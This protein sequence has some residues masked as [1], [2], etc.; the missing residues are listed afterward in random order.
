[1]SLAEQNAAAIEKVR[2]SLNEAAA[3]TRALHDAKHPRA[4]VLLYVI[5]LAIAE[6]DEMGAAARRTAH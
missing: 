4:P 2:Q 5:E 6:A 3:I 1:M